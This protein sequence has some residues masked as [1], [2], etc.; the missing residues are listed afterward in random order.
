MASNESWSKI[1]KDYNILKHDFKKNPFDISAD[2][3]KKS[4]QK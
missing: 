3:I 2:Q 4:C 1:F